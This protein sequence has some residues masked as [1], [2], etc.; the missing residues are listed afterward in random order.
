MPTVSWCR[1][2]DSILLFCLTH[3][4]FTW[5]LSK[6]NSKSNA[7]H[8]QIYFH[9]TEWHLDLDLYQNDKF[10]YHH[11]LEEYIYLWNNFGPSSYHQVHTVWTLDSRTDEC[12]S[13]SQQQNWH[14]NLSC[15]AKFSLIYIWPCIQLDIG[16]L[17]IRSPLQSPIIIWCPF[18]PPFEWWIKVPVSDNVM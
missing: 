8:W 11:H 4:V 2:L 14:F 18:C 15:R 9:Y 16:I 10:K 17:S 7:Y 1:H 5:R 6:P 3:I 12:Q 13:Y